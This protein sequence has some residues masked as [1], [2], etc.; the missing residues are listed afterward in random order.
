MEQAATKIVKKLQGAG[1]KA[2]FAGGSVRDMLM[3]KVSKD[4]DIATSAKPEQIEKLLSKTVPVGKKFGVILVLEK[5][6]SFE[7]ATF[8]SDS[9]YSDGRRPDYVTYTNAKEDALRRDFTINGMFWDPVKKQVL[10]Y[11]GGKEDLGRKTIRFIGDPDKRIKEDNLRILRAIR[12]RNVLGFSYDEASWRAICRNAKLIKNVSAERIR[13]ELNKMFD[14]KWRENAFVDL[15]RAGIMKHLFPEFE[16]CKGVAQP[17]NYHGE[18]DVF[19]HILRAIGTLPPKAPLF[20]SWAVLL[21]DIGKPDT[22][23]VAPDRI[24]FDGHVLKSVEIAGDILRRLKFPKIEQELIIW[25]IDNHMTVGDI[26]KM[27]VSKQRR[28]LLDPR[29]KWLLEVHRADALGSLPGDLKLYEK[30]KT[31]INAEKGRKIPKPILGGGD[32]MKHF[33]LK[34]GP[35][36]GKLIEQAHEA[37]LEGKVR[38]K[39]EALEFLERGIKGIKG[40]NGF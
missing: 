31:M 17:K 14:G 25:L 40:N 21:H 33:S 39:K 20:V 16:K 5:G 6:H 13:D 24:R 9:G 34:P 23:R 35:R 18:G 37:Q 7:V 32:I 15:D 11:V 28:F 27:R 2:Y 3:G 10:D 8:R 29:M 26:P 19:S 12:F 30:L 1:F 22:F 38:T 4:F 36:I